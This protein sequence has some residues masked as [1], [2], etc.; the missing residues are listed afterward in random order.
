[1][2]ALLD[3]SSRAVYAPNVLYVCIRLSVKCGSVVLCWCVVS[4]VLVFCS[5][6]SVLLFVLF[7]P[8]S[9]YVADD[10]C[11]M[12]FRRRVDFGHAR[13]VYRCA[14]IPPCL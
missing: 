3:T 7:G 6:F 5:C 12:R 10:S 13:L 9:R 4:L 2:N 11:V 8:L 1:M 14:Y